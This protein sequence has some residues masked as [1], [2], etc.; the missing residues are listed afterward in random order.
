MEFILASNYPDDGKK[1]LGVVQDY[2]VRSEMSF[3]HGRRADLRDFP[4]NAHCWSWRL[5]RC[6]VLSTHFL[7]LVK[8]ALFC[9]ERRL[10]LHWLEALYHIPRAAL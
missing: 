1:M 10:G 4:N 9:Q 3:L 2:M 6:I 7:L 5:W 8:G